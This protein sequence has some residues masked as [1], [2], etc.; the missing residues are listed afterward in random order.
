MKWL[1]C[2]VLICALPVSLVAQS[3]TNA[4]AVTQQIITIGNDSGGAVGSRANEIAHIRASGQRVEITGAFCS[5]SCTLYLG[6]GD[7]CINPQTM[8][9]FHGPS[10]S[11]APMPADQFEHWSQLM[12]RHYREPL[13]GWFLREA[14]HDRMRLHWLPGTQLISMGYR[15]C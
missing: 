12:A 6:A 14:R 15:R 13:R 1:L 10:Y 7:V 3:Q 4:Y 9:G 11:G 2:L 8:F 5:S